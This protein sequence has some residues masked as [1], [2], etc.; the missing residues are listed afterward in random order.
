MSFKEQLPSTARDMPDLKWNYEEVDMFTVMMVDPGFAVAH[1]VY[2]NVEENG[3]EKREVG[4][5][6][7]NSCVPFCNTFCQL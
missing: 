3:Q 4:F 1:A 2:I 6:H 5:G 7:V